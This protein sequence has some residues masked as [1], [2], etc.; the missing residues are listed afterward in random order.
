M[1]L[2]KRMSNLLSANLN[3][4][5]DQCEDP[6]KLLRQAVRDM[7]TALGQLMDGAARAIAHQKLLARQLHDQQQSI[8]QR[9]RT[10][11]LALARGDEAAARREL[12]RKIEH[13]QLADALAQQT[14]SAE[15][16]SER[17]RSQV[18]AMRLKLAEARRRLAEIS[19]RNRAAVA[20]RKFVAALPTEANG[21][22]AINAFQR[23]CAKVEQS[24]AE[25]EA[26]LELLG[27]GDCDDT[28]DVDVE[29]ELRAMREAAGHVTP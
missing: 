4:L 17:L 25:T 10:A 8:A 9:V 28:F 1:G 5:I 27:V 24:E 16:L 11:E 22:D 21:G 29:E 6:E 2:L 18:A 13:T 15:E 14:A 12:R 7:E 20:R 23:I 3:D 19:A 26:L